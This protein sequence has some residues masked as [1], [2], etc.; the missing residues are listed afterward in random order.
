MFKLRR[1]GE[2]RLVEITRQPD[3]YPV[4][5]TW[6][7]TLCETRVRTGQMHRT[8][9]YP[10]HAT[11]AAIIVHERLAPPDGTRIEEAV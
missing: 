1:T 8:D 6:R 10:A 7:C 3:A 5:R 2:A 9:V 11:M 4:G